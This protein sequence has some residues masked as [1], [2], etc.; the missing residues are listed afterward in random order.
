M[1][2]LPPLTQDQMNDEQRAIYKEF[3]EA[4][5]RTGVAITHLTWMR[6]PE[7]A[8]LIVQFGSFMRHG[9]LDYR[10]R[11]LAIL[12]T[13]REAKS[14]V[15]WHLHLPY[16][17]E[18]GIEEPI[19]EALAEKRRPDFT[20]DDDI[21]LYEV[22]MELMDGYKLSQKTYENA[23]K[24]LGPKDLVELVA[25]TGYYTLMAMQI[26]AF[27]FELPPGEKPPFVD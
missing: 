24:V 4:H 26:G 15:E 16:A 12:I 25:I 8:R 3:Q 10:K 7:L 5:P 1:S 17:R 18:S 21:A 22:V 20:R 11:E 6:S 27:N 23:I 13:G 9:C 19:I 14:P 2:R